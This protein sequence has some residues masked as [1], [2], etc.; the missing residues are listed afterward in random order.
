MRTALLNLSLCMALPLASFGQIAPH[1]KAVDPVAIV[2]GQPISEQD[3]IDSL[4][5]QWM[6]LRTQEYGFVSRI[7]G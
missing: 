2:A 1:A 7:C 3:L 6:Q 4:G 5:P